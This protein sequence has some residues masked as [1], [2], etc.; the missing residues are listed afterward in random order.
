MREPILQP[1]KLTRDGKVATLTLTRPAMLNALGADGDGEAF[2][3]ACAEINGDSNIRAAILTG[4]GRAFSAGGDVKAM[5]RQDEDVRRRRRRRYP[6]GLSAPATSIR[7][8]A[9]CTTWMCR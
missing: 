1:L 6:P 3:A 8:C 2:A 7:S 5:P 4:E 9:P